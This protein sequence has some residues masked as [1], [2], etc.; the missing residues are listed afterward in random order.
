[1][2]ES[3]L[4]PSSSLLA[5]PINT[6][7]EHT[8]ATKTPSKTTD[9]PGTD[10]DVASAALAAVQAA[11]ADEIDA[12]L[13]TTPILKIGQPLTREVQDDLAEVGEF[14]NTATGEGI[15]NAVEFVLSFYQKGR[16]AADRDTNRAYVAFGSTIPDHWADLVGEEFVGTPFSEHPDAEETFKKRVN[17]KEIQ[18]G[19]G[20]LISTTHNFTGF[21]LVEDIETKE[22]DPQPVRL[23]LQRTNVPSVKKWLTLIST[24]LRNRPQWDKTFTLGTE[25]KS[26]DKGT[27]YLLTV[28][29]GRDTTPDEK[30]QALQLAEAVIA[31]RVQDNAEVDAPAKPKDD[32]GLAV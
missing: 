11:Q 22:I 23:S 1:M 10:L 16:F 32:G 30:A 12:D 25:K 31:G 15:G 4:S 6:P 28:G 13:L 3:N 21:A 9:E 17:A 29:V 7:K 5:R 24:K 8:I 2:L 27:A 18:W 14:I 19:K 20:P 26:F